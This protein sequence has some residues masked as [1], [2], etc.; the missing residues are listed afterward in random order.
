VGKRYQPMSFRG[1]IRKQEHKIG[2]R[3][4]KKEK[5]ESKRENVK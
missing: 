2:K 1:N 5:R 3:Q 4:K